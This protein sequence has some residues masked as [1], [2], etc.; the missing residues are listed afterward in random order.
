MEIRY[1]SSKSRGSKIL[2]FADVVLGEGIIVRGFRIVDGEK[3]LF[4]AVPSRSFTVDGNPRFVNQVV[5]TA[6]ELRERFLSELLAGYRRWRAEG[7]AEQPAASDAA[8][9]PPF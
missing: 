5:F 8:E 3:G 2:A 4:A 9:A 6:P 7:G 1:Y